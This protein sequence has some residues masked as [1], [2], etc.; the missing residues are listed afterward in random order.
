MIC[1]S[2]CLDACLHFIFQNVCIY[3]ASMHSKIFHSVVFCRRR[4]SEASHGR[5]AAWQ[6]DGGEDARTITRRAHCRETSGPNYSFGIFS[7]SAHRRDSSSSGWPTHGRKTGRRGDVDSETPVLTA[8]T[9]HRLQN[10]S[11]CSQSSLLSQL[12]QSLTRTKTAHWQHPPLLLLLLC[13][14]CTC[15]GATVAQGV[16]PPVNPKWVWDVEVLFA[17]TFFA[18]AHERIVCTACACCGP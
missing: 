13:L 14:C 18:C 3:H 9:A 2:V 6:E 17:P 12:L 11:Q 15:T 8:C 4:D 10:F 7:G 5:G 1:L 16:A